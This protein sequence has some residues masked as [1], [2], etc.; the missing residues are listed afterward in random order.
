MALKIVDGHRTGH[1]KR[2]LAAGVGNVSERI[3]KRE[4]MYGKGVTLWCLHRCCC[5]LAFSR[6]VGKTDYRL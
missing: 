5:R 1:T 2:S 4:E 6:R 3:P